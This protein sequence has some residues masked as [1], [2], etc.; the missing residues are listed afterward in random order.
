MGL[1]KIQTDFDRL[2]LLDDS[3]WNHNNHY[4][5]FLLRLLPAHCTESL[6][7]D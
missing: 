7:T 3:G 6:E 4:S 5:S 2:A 1:L